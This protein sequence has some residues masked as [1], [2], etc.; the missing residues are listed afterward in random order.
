VEPF[1]RCP[2]GFAAGIRGDW[3][4][5][6]TAWAGLNPYEEALELTEAPDAPTAFDGLRRLDDM[7]AAATAALVRRRLTVRGLPGVPRGPQRTTRSNPAR[8]T[9]RQFAILT[10]LA[11][12]LTSAEIADRLVLSKRTVDN[13]VT[14]IL[15]RLG[16]AGRREAVEVAT[17]EGWL[18]DPAQTS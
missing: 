17:R 11:D 5:A 10:L 3:R 16:V 1:D 9:G 13:H 7:G 6:A 8:L 15:S 14:A 2:A 18:P 12:G 4:A